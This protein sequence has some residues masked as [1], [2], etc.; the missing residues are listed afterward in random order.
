VRADD[1][2]AVLVPSTGNRILKTLLSRV[3]GAVSLPVVDPRWLTTRW[4]GTGA[5]RIRS[6]LAS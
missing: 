5:P 3:K 2:R 6:A 4:I 1:D